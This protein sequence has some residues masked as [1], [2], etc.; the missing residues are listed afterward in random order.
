MGIIFAQLEQELPARHLVGIAPASTVEEATDAVRDA[1]KLA[2]GQS[3][4]LEFAG[5][6]LDSGTLAASEVPADAVLEATRT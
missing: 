3:V 2:A 5:Q 1:F 6:A 4:R